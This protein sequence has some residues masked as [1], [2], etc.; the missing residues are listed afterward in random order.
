M[1][2]EFLVDAVAQFLQSSEWLD[3]ISGFL[4]SKYSLFLSSPDEPK[5]SKEHTLE[6]YDVFLAFK[7]LAERLLEKLIGDLGCTGEDLVLLLEQNLGQQTTTTGERR[8]FIRTLLAFDDYDA[9]F[10]KIS[11]YAA[12]QQGN[13]ACHCFPILYQMPNAHRFKLLANDRTE[14]NGEISE[15]K[16]QEAIAKSILEANVF[17]IC[18]CEPLV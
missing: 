14:G 10:N 6:Q 4:Q 17:A 3:A 12:E 8:F 13:L 2:K 18:S 7:D 9:F 11:Q 15:W 5:E 16:L 1:D